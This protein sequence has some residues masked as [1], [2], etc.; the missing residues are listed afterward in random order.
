MWKLILGRGTVL[1][2]ARPL[3]PKEDVIPLHQYLKDL[4]PS[5]PLVRI[6]VP[7]AVQ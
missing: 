6:L 3:H 4:I 5:R 1:S 7:T 2:D